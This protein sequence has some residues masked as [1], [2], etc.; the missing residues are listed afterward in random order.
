MKLIPAI[1]LWDGKVVRLKRGDPYLSTVYSDNPVEIAK[2]WEK[3]GA[4]LLHLVD[5]SA[6]LGEKKDNFDIIK[7][8]LSELNIPIEVGGGIRSLDKAKQLILL[9]AER[10]VIGTGS[11][12][13]NFLDSL[14]KNFGTDKIAIGL[15]LLGSALSVEG[16]KLRT[17]INGYDFVNYLIDK[18]L[19]WIIYTDI[20]RDGTLEGPNVTGIKSF[21]RFEKINFIASGGVSA[22]EDLKLLQQD[23]P[24]IWGV[25]VGKAIYEGKFTIEQAGSIFN[26][27]I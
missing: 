26:A 18:G 17:T 7:E 14:L 16:W 15:D 22:L 3:E 8:I 12:D 13:E 21:S 24:F 2:K 20:S 19:K 6:A 10:I 23:V 1:D 11:T 4:Q 5:L 9:G 25:I 27:G